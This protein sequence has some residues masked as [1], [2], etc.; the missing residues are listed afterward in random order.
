[1]SSER[2]RPISGYEGLYEVSRDGRIR[3]YHKEAP[4]ELSAGRRN[5]YGHLA[6]HLFD[7]NGMR[8]TIYVHQLV[9]AA[10]LG[11][12][13]HGM[14]IRHLNGNPRDNRHENLAY[15]TLSD[16][17]HDRVAHGNHY[18]AQ[19]S[20]CLRGHPFDAANTYYRKDGTRRCRTCKNLCM[21][22]TRARRRA[23]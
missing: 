16:N 7:R 10:F 2:W 18:Q 20:H 6:V 19:K 15:G 12:R 14:Q 3:S 22:A 11:P 23:A 4:H 1:M 13:L 21:Q 8:R 9:A 17:M 5:Q